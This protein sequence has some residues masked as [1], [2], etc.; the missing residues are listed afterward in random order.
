MRIFLLTPVLAMLASA[1]SGNLSA[2]STDSTGRPASLSPDQPWPPAESPYP[3]A[4]AGSSK[5]EL[6]YEPV[7][8]TKVYPCDPTPGPACGATQ[9]DCLGGPCVDGACAPCVLAYGPMTAGSE[10]LLDSANAYFRSNGIKK[11]PL[12]GGAAV[13]LAA[14]DYYVVALRDGFVY[15]VATDMQGA[16]ELWRVP[17]EGGGMALVAS[18][19]D[20]SGDWVF[21]GNIMY[22][23]VQSETGPLNQL[24]S[25]NL[26]SG[27]LTF[28]ASGY[29]N[30]GLM[31]AGSGQVWGWNAQ[32]PGTSFFIT[33]ESG[34]APTSLRSPVD[35]SLARGVLFGGQVYFTVSSGYT[36]SNFQDYSRGGIWRMWP[37]GSHAAEIVGCQPGAFW[38]KVDDAAMYWDVHKHLMKLTPGGEPVAVYDSNKYVYGLAMDERAVY[39]TDENALMKLA[40]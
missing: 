36:P 26:Q 29:M 2:D 30:I 1:C 35:G 3:A 11:V 32:V 39:W 28:L 9:Q 27:T 7:I 5:C 21:D 31:A 8:P 33:P 20:R 19:P 40:R 14:E 23:H 24:W 38:L 12:N 13:Q 17:V 22:L 4:A 6:S 34:G 25:V 10:I 16:H 18:L 15:A 37:D